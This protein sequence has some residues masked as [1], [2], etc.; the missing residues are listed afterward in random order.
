MEKI[1]FSSL[2]YF[3]LKI[4]AIIKYFGKKGM[5]NK[6]IHEEFVETLGKESPSFSTMSKWAAE[7]MRGVESFEDD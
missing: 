6:E 5:H 3:L 4:R 2:S 1:D 7:F